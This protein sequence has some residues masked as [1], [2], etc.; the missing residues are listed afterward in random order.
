MKTAG[1]ETDTVKRIGLLL[2]PSFARSSQHMDKPLPRAVAAIL[3]VLTPSSWWF[4]RVAPSSEQLD[5]WFASSVH[6]PPSVSCAHLHPNHCLIEDTLSTC[7]KI[8][9]AY[10]LYALIHLVPHLLFKKDRFSKKALLK[11]LVAILRTYGWF[12]AYL[13]MSRMV[14]CYTKQFFGAF[15]AVPGL[16]MVQLAGFSIFFEPPH[17]RSEMGLY[18]LS[19]LAESIPAVAT[20]RKYWIDVPFGVNLLFG[21]TMGVFSWT[22]FTD[23]KMIKPTFAWLVKILMGPQM[24]P[25]TESKEEQPKDA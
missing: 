6:A 23:E 5:E 15:R 13:F 10:K 19:K 12:F 24:E 14:Y 16:A 22:H 18:F 8:N 25:Q 2:D 7:R 17:R 21:F 11:V 9:N 3:K 4:D 20:K 1:L